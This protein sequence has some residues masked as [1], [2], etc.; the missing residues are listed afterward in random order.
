LIAVATAAIAAL[1]AGCGQVAHVDVVSPGHV[2]TVPGSIDASGATDVTNALQSFI[3]NTPDGSTIVFPAG[4]HYRVEGTVH[5]MHRNNLAFEGTGAKVFATTPG[6]RERSQFLVRDSTNIKFHG[7]EVVGAHPNAG[8]SDSSYVSELEAQHAFQLE[9]VRNVELNAVNAHDVYGDFV[10]I[11]R[12][13]NTRTW[14]DGVWVHDSTFARNGRMGITVTAGRHVVIERNSIADT[15]RSVIDMEPDASSGGAE[16]VRIDS[17]RVIRGRLN[18][19]SAGK[20]GSTRTNDI[21]D[22]TITNN[23]L[24]GHILN[25]MVAT[26]ENYNQRR[27]NFTVVGNTSDTPAYGVPPLRF[28]NVDGVRVQNN[29]QPTKLQPVT[30]ANCTNALVTGNFFSLP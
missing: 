13:N 15:R 26:R 22:I 28:W 6:D 5:V 17:N 18:F 21:H 9:G 7:L 16:Y 14:S 2:V 8:T 10:Y 19:V 27:A 11:T 29:R 30:V 12:D 1:G 20:S 3:L 25:V 4:A 24:K 23:V